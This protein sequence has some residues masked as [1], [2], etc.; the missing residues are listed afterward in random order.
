MT[1][2]KYPSGLTSSDVIKLWEETS[3]RIPFLNHYLLTPWLVMDGWVNDFCRHAQS[4]RRTMNLQITDRID[5]DIFCDPLVAYA[6]SS[7]MGTIISR[8]LVHKRISIVCDSY[9]EIERELSQF[10]ISDDL[11]YYDSLS[12]IHYCKVGQKDQIWGL[13]PIAY[14]I[15][16]AS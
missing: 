2:F 9:E 8:L 5:L 4:A 13:T 12:D 3:N 15:T 16:L 11:S 7:S 10:D 1:N 14:K 6:I